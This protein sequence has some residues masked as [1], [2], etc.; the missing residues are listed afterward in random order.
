MRGP[1]VVRR[2]EEEPQVVI[3]E[4]DTLTGERPAHH[5][6]DDN[7]VL[8]AREQLSLV[9]REVAG[10]GF[11]SRKAI[12]R[13]RCKAGRVTR[14]GYLVAPLVL[15]ERPAPVEENRPQHRG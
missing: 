3:L 4:I 15:H 6:G 1:D 14:A 2:A 7:L 5:V 12:P 11:C 10:E 13:K 9:V 8:A